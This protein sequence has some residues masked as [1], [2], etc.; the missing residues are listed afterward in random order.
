MEQDIILAG[1]GG[2]GI[3]TIARAISAAALRRGLTV[4]QAEVHGMSQRGGSVQSHLRIADHEIASDLIPRGRAH[5]IVSVEPLEALRYLDYLGEDGALVSGSNP[6]VNLA[7]YPALSELTERIARHP[8]HVLLDAE[9]LARLAGSARAANVLL[10]GAASPYLQIGFDE[11]EA[12]V[13]ALLSDKGPR[14]VEVS[15][16]ALRMGRSAALA[17]RDGLGRGL[18]AARVQAA[19]ERFSRE[20]LLGESSAPGPQVE[21]EAGETLGASERAA[22]ARIL[23]RAERHGRTQLFEHEVYML[24]ELVGAIS[25]PRYLFVRRGDVVSESALSAFRGDQVVLKIV[26]PDVVHKSDADGVSFVRRDAPLVNAGVE[27]LIAAHSRGARVEGVLIVE[28]VEE[29]RSGFGSELFVGIRATREFGP[30]MAAGLGGVD[31]EYIAGKML[32]GIA[33]AK[34]VATQVTAERFLDLFQRTAAYEL[35]SGQ[36]R[37]HP[38]VVSDGQL[39][40]CFRAFLMVAREFCLAGEGPRLDELEVNPFAFRQQRLVP[41]DG[42]GRLGTP[43]SAPPA[44]PIEKIARLLEPRSIAVLGVSATSMNLGRIVLN[45]VRAAGFP[46][47]HLYAIKPGVESIDGLRCVESVAA[48]PE[49]ADLLVVAATAPHLPGLVTEIGASRKVESVILVTAGVGETEGSEAIREETLA[50]MRGIRQRDDG[51]PVFVGPN[52]LG[53]QSR[54]GR[55]DTFFIPPHKLH[56]RMIANAGPRRRVAI[57]A[58]S[59]AF[60]LTRLNNLE[61]LNPALAISVGN[62]SDL[63]HSDL[64][65]GVVRRDDVDVVGVYAEGFNDLDGAAF[66]EAVAEAT[67]AGKLVI[68]YKAGRTEPGRS[69]AAGHTASVAGDYDVCQ[70]AAAQAGAIVVDTFKEFEQLVELAGAL[71]G[72]RVEGRRIAALSNAGCEVVAMADA[73]RGPRYSVR[74][75]ALDE[76]SRER[77]RGVLAA[78]KLDRLVNARNP[79]DI[80]PMADEAAYEGCARVLL[81]SPEVDALVLA[82]VPLTPMLRTTPEEIARGGSLVEIVPA[83]LRDYDKPLCFVVDCGT[84][85]DTFALAVRETGVPVMRSVDQAIRS[86]GR[87]LCHRTRDAGLRHDG[88]SRPPAHRHGEAQ[89]AFEPGAVPS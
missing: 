34:A 47:E 6:V 55:Y 18:D 33:V 48:L 70:A 37:G 22:V 3:L 81:E 4:K 23:E 8:E 17:Y 45:N 63:T 9:K 57:I 60:I 28:F 88:P 84:L 14:A 79:L 26:S 44:R 24:M 2:Q 61:V 31:T 27:R 51:G 39:L 66:L 64:L 86:M 10:L 32:P 77:L 69:A 83:L 19:V 36:V 38:R 7:N 78:R 87:Y 1:V 58:Q 11:L 13:V 68:F 21:V 43:T 30:V 73:I 76:P 20:E 12:S 89:A 71:H 62:Q 46:V 25:P 5:L 50:A 42:R 59:G 29:A 41:L 53:I 75:A 49:T 40:R 82:C 56:P 67:A 85:Y 74:M 54:P 15:L 16:A 72:K 35:L 65:R 80:G 52:S